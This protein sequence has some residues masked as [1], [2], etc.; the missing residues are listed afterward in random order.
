MTKTLKTKQAIVE[1]LRGVAIGDLHLDKL[2]AMIPKFNSIVISF[3]RDILLRAERNGCD[4]AVFLGDVFNYMNASE[5]AQRLFLELLVEFKDSPMAIRVIEG[6]HGYKRN[7]MGSLSMLAMLED[8]SLI[9][10][11]FITKPR[12]EVIKGIPLVF[13]PHPYTS[14]ASIKDNGI[15]HSMIV[16]S[17]LLDQQSYDQADSLGA[18]VDSVLR[19]S[20]AFGH[21]TRSG[22]TNDNGTSSKEGVKYE[23]SL[24]CQ[25]YIIGHLHTPQIVGSTIY[26]GT[27]YQTSFGESE[28]KGYGLFK[29]T[30]LKSGK[31]N[32][33]YQQVEVEPPI[34]LVNI[35]AS[36][37]RHLPVIDE[38]EH[39]TWY[40]ISTMK[41]FQLPKE[42]LTHKQVVIGNSVSTKSTVEQDVE[43]S[44][45]SFDLEGSLLAFLEAEGFESSD[46]KIARKLLK[47]AKSE[48]GY[49]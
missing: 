38:M 47:S 27:F 21:F 3:C 23:S 9:N 25:H 5:E 2:S 15:L 24:D 46:L 18:D 20:I 39:N 32:L 34:R 26:P 35:I 41:G 49:S 22:S 13:L 31:V 30:L 10:A 28:N 11:Q 33:K 37:K 43:A 14:L 36:S 4:V 40:K 6:N 17:G 42:Y 48:L 12:C 45:E 29:A 7:G 1:E 16:D 44:D 8:F 19:P